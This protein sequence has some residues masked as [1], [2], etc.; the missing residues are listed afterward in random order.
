MHLIYWQN[1][2]LK[3]DKMNNDH[4]Q[5]ECLCVINIAHGFEANEYADVT[6]YWSV[7]KETKR[8]KLGEKKHKSKRRTWRWLGFAY[9]CEK[10]KTWIFGW[11][12]VQDFKH[13]LNHW[14]YYS[15]FNI[16]GTGAFVYTTCWLSMSMPVCVFAHTSP[17]L[18]YCENLFIEFTWSLY[19]SI[20]LFVLC[21]YLSLVD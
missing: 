12:E 16:N 1:I 13:L 19:N 5:R 17:F 3:W 4:E 8:R 18:L 7:F 9:A 10:C 14:E 15:S 21:L 6:R 20:A 2:I 11:V